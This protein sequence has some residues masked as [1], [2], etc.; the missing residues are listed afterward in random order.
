VIVLVAVAGGLGAV[1]RFAL[2]TAVR[3]RVQ[4]YPLGTLLV[5]VSGSLLLG[6]VAGLVAAGVL[7]AEWRDVAGA[8]YLGG[9]TTFSTAAVEAVRLAQE[10]RGVPAA[11]ASV[12]MLLLA[13]A[14]AALGFA[15]AGLLS[16]R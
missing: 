11:V 1:C 6:L 16:G 14:A 12:G 5:N 13:A 15:A 10:R 2:D 4:G 9:Y 8:G 7:P 3:T